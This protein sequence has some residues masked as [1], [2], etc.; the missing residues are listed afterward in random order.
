MEK[1]I[2]DGIIIFCLGDPSIR[3][4]LPGKPILCKKHEQMTGRFWTKIAEPSNKVITKQDHP[5]NICPCD[6]AP[7]N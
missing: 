4:T 2:I 5:F 6:Y 3:D 1:K 7:W